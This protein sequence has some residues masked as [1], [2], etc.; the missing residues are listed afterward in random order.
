MSFVR[1]LLGF[2][3][4]RRKFWLFP[5]IIILLSFG[6]VIVLAGGTAIAPFIYTLF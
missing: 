5:I 2:L 4:E 6:V 3:K 1:D